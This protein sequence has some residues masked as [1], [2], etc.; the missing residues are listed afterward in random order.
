MLVY[1][2]EDNFIGYLEFSALG[3]CASCLGWKLKTYFKD[4]TW[5][6]CLGL[7]H[8]FSSFYSVGK[9][10]SLE[11]VFM[12]VSDDPHIIKTVMESF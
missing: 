8:M 6:P 1:F 4:V 9:S 7:E 10:D 2:S 5:V 11:S 12:A 3:I